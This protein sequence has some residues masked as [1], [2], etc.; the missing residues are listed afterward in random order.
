MSIWRHR[1]ASFLI[2]SV[3]NVKIVTFLSRRNE[4]F[5]RFWPTKN[6]RF[7][8]VG[9]LI[10]E[11][12]KERERERDREKGGEREWGRVCAIAALKRE[13]ERGVCV[14]S[15]RADNK[16]SCVWSI[17]HIVTPSLSLSLSLSTTYSIFAYSL[18]LSLTHTPSL[19]L[20]PFQHP[21]SPFLH[22]HSL[23]L[24]LSLI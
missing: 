23:S 14:L 5:T 2:T 21:L 4:R 7:V 11:R 10:R 18:P 19:S 9:K 1:T 17:Y 12:P 13:R 8:V 6:S 24:S 20:N 3:L 16:R 15:S 22:T